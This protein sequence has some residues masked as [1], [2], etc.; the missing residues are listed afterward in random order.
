MSGKLDYSVRY[1]EG[2]QSS[3]QWC[4]R[5]YDQHDNQIGHDLAQHQFGVEFSIRDIRWFPVL[6]GTS[7]DVHEPLV[8][9]REDFIL[10]RL[11]PQGQFRLFGSKRLLTTFSLR[12]REWNTHG[13]VA[14]ATTETCE[15]SLLLPQQEFR[16]TVELIKDGAVIGGSLE[17]WKL[18]G[19][20]AEENYLPE[21]PQKFKLLSEDTLCDGL[22]NQP[23]I[24]RLGSVTSASSF[25]LN[26]TRKRSA[27]S[28]LT[29]LQTKTVIKAFAKVILFILITWS[30]VQSLESIWR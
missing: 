25:T 22:P 27:G 1:C 17:L 21:P 15:I 3:G 30:V 4:L 20:Y 14:H 2:P 26:F 8:F 10:A 7:K 5:E 24:P 16:S 6:E 18:A 29:A 9:S 28:L 19:L 12:I 23:Q 13:V 11:V